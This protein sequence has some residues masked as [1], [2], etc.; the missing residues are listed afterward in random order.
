MTMPPD[1]RPI[2]VQY[3]RRP[4]WRKPDNTVYVG[5]SAAGDGRWGN[6]Y[7][8]GVGVWHVDGTAVMAL[9]RADAVRYFR[10]W[11]GFWLFHQP[12]MLEELRG[13][14][15]GCWCPLDQPCHRDVLL[16]LANR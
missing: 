1:M 16:E 15:L 14:N 11:L 8:I 4:G 9:N 3:S 10:E 6:R 7:R 2:G 12:A 5:R 13:K